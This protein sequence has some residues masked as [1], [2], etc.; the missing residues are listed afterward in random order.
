MLP[1]C[2]Q[3]KFPRSLFFKSFLVVGFSSRLLSRTSIPTYFHNQI[4]KLSM[5]ASLSSSEHKVSSAESRN[6]SAPRTNPRS[7]RSNHVGYSRY[8]L[9]KPRA[10]IILEFSLKQIYLSEFLTRKLVEVQVSLVVIQLLPRSRCG[11]DSNLL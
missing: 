3:S 2:L 1:K 7:A 6:L 9:Q 5:S 8:F 10:C 4:P 11:I